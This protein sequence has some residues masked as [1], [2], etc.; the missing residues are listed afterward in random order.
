MIHRDHGGTHGWDNPRF[1][2]EDADALTNGAMLPVVLSI[3]CSSGAFQDDERSF[4]T[5]A[6][7]NPNGGA[8][9]VF[10]DTEI[11]PTDHNTQLAFGFLDALLPRVLAA[12]A[13]RASSAWA[14]R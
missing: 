8:A 6:L 3:N 14:T 9:G 13:R 11:S 7:V 4:A 5:Q 1:T 2:S 10:G 12:R